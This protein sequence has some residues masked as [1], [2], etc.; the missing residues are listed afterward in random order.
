MASF[1]DITV[2]KG[3]SQVFTFL[4]VFVI[5]YGF[6]SY[7]KL[8]GDNKGLQALLGLILGML[9]LFSPPLVAVIES[10]SPWFVTIFIF[11]A[12]TVVMFK[13]RGVSD[14]DIA[15]AVKRQTGLQWTLVIMALIILAF[16]LSSA[17]GQTAGPY[18]QEQGGTAS[19][20]GAVSSGGG[21]V[22]AVSNIHGGA[23]VGAGSTATSDF[24]TNLQSSLFHPRMLGMIVVILIALAAV[25]LLTQV[26]RFR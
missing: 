22:G 21:V 23:Q 1:L 6:T 9:T 11:I 17:F 5:V 25:G 26:P 19:S 16:G 14:S 12:L 2:L 10:V 20:S 8:F 7:T 15:S 3:F 4:L 18:L 13:M 24:K